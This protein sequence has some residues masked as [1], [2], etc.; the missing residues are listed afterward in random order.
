MTEES[1][2]NDESDEEWRDWF[3]Y[4]CVSV[5]KWIGGEVLSGFISRL[6]PMVNLMILIWWKIRDWLTDLGV[7]VQKWLGGA[8]NLMKNTGLAHSAWRVGSKMAWR[9]RLVRLDWLGGPEDEYYEMN[10]MNNI[11]LAHSTWSVGLKIAW[12]VRQS[13]EK[14][15]TG[16]QRLAC[17]LKNILEDQ[18]WQAW[19]VGW[20]WWWIWWNEYDE[21]YSTSSQCLACR[22]VNG[23]E[24]Q[25]WQDWL[26]RCTWRG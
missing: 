17:G 5:Q 12:R 24:G 8:G 26:V 3:T 16:S 13:D 7:S 14:Y 22:F 25:V 2:I 11:V 21:K 20:T 15:G 19:L 1:L 23:L 9:S 6:D 18:V 10:P 4:I